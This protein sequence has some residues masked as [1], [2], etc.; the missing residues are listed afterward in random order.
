MLVPIKKSHSLSF[1]Y[2]GGCNVSIFVEFPVN[3]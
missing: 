1:S 3:L 2:I